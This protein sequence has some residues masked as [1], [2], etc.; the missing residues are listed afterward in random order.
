MSADDLARSRLKKWR[1][2]R[3]VTQKQLGEAAGHDQPWASA[4]LAGEI[5]AGLTELTGMAALFGYPLSALFDVTDDPDADSLLNCYR[6]MAADDKKL[7]LQ[8]ALKLCPDPPPL[9]S[10]KRR[11][12]P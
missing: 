8:W 5:N 7:L 1:T 10:A 11:R 12:G 4:Y 6:A 2:T 3:Q 9:P